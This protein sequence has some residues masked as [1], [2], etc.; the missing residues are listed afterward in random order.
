MSTAL[1]LFDQPKLAIPAHVGNFFGE[2]SNVLERATIPSLGVK[3][4]VWAISLNGETTNLTK[5][6][7]GDEV[8]LSVMRVVVLD[9]AQ[10]RGRSYY[11]GNYD[12]ANTSKP[13]C[14]SDD[15]ISPSTG[16][17]EPQ[18]SKCA[19]CPMSV[20]GS[21]ITDTSKATT[22]CAQHRI[23]VVVPANK[24]DFA[25]LRFKIAVTS[26]YDGQSPELEAQGWYAF[27]NLLDLMRSKGVQHTAALV[28][29]MKFDPNAAYP[30]VI[31]SPDRWLSDAELAIVRDRVKSDEVKNLL[32]GVFTEVAA[33][34]E[35]PVAL[36]RATPAAAPAKAPKAAP[37][38]A[39]VVDDDDEDA[40]LEQVATKPAAKPAKA[41]VVDDDDEDEPAPAPKAKAAP[42]AT[43]AAKVTKP[44]PAPV[45][46]VEDD[47]EDE[48]P[49][50]P[51]KAAKAAPAVS[52]DVPSEVADLL[53]DW[54]DD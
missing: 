25:A 30:K 20:K 12:P 47:D 17:A 52:T 14:W 43:P 19:S 48:A 22:A 15:G 1:T 10:R 7:D 23:L 34:P 2:E 26:D 5:E 51:A 42:K 45:V 40:L 49:A 9:Y 18:A 33:E 6:V 36:T 41:A 46:V 37:A 16:V 35:A 31:F 28:I 4:K 50:K 24:L 39:T 32:A 3:G 54:G 27:N 21:K 8:P 53:N 44:K 38:K 13:K 29:K 11:E